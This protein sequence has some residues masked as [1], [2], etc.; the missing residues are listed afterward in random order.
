M[1]KK[2]QAPPAPNLS[3]VFP[4]NPTFKGRTDVGGQYRTTPAPSPPAAKRRPRPRQP[5]LDLAP[6]VRAPKKQRPAAKQA[7]H[8]GWYTR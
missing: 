8:G 2:S 6:S 7:P 4:K 1:P 3:G 5:A